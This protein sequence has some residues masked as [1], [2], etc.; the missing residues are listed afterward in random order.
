VFYSI[1]RPSR[2]LT[3][4]GDAARLSNPERGSLHQMKLPLAH[5]GVVESPEGLTGSLK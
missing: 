5:G 1:G 4:C 2:A 3:T